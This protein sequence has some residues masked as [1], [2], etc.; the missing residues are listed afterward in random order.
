M[1]DSLWEDWVNAALGVW[2]F[3]SP[4]FGI[5]T[6]DGA[7]AWNAYICGVAI[8]V[9]AVAGIASPQ[10]YAQAVNLVLGL[11]V[12]SYGVVVGDTITAQAV[13]AKGN[14]IAVG[15]IVAVLSLIA[16]RA[17]LPRRIR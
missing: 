13:Y 11:W 12:L 2:L 10:R 15:G 17:P 4:M 9:V 5:G 6:P 16:M 14:Q 7:M 1:Q 3:F 8:T